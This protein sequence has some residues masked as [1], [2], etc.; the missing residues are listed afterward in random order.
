ML[1]IGVEY[2]TTRGVKEQSQCWQSFIEPLNVDLLSCNLDPGGYLTCTLFLCG[3]VSLCILV[4]F[5]M[6]VL[7]VLH[8][9]AFSVCPFKPPPAGSILPIYWV[10][11]HLIDGWTILSWSLG[12]IND[13]LSNGISQFEWFHM[14]VRCISTKLRQLAWHNTVMSDSRNESQLQISDRFMITTAGMLLCPSPHCDSL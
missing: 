10:L 1:I 9:H 4:W 6:V 7:F 5:G 2:L 12:H 8:T 14:T 3:C 13:R 11:S